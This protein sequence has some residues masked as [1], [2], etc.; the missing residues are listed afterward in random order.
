MSAT[1]MNH[2]GRASATAAVTDPIE[3]SRQ[4]LGEARATTGPE[5]CARLDE[6]ASKLRGVDPAGIIGDVARIAF[7]ANLYN[8]L[9]LHRLCLKPVRG[10]MLRHPR[11]F[12][13]VAYEVGWRPYTLNLIEH[14]LLRA[15]RRP[16]LRIRRTMRPGDPR[17][18][19]A[20]SEPDPRIHFALNCG[21][22]SCPPIRDYAPAHLDTQLEAATRAYLQSEAS[23][24]RERRRVTLPRLLRVY[25]RDFGDRAEQVDF[26]ARHLPELAELLA[27]TTRVRID[28]GRFDW[29]VA[30]RSPA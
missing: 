29:T 9:L 24:D 30:P 23:L 26:A 22:R 1:V 4:L 12:A 6:L 13:K 14:G 21:A 11:L 16:P 19:A 5:Q 18:A 10:S 8:A 17:L 15:N 25:E 2:G 28:Y 3:L 20:P 7:W 27:E